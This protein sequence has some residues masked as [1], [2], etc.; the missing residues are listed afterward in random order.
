M[1]RFAWEKTLPC[2]CA[3]LVLAASA[4]HSAEARALP[5][6]ASATQTTT[7]TQ[8]A[9]TQPAATQ[10]AATQPPATPA[11]PPTQTPAAPPAQP[12]PA[13]TPAPAAAT[14]TPAGFKLCQQNNYERVGENHWHYSGSVECELE[15]ENIRFSADEIDY[16]SDTNRFLA[17]GHVVFISSGS[18]IS[19]ERA[20]FNSKT[21]TGTFFNAFG[22]ASV[23]EKIDKSFFGTQEPDAYFYGET[24]EKLGVDKYRITKGG[25]TTC[26]Q[27]TPRWEVAATS[28]TL[29]LDKRAI[30][31]NALLKV[32]DVPL[33]YLPAMYYPINKEDR[34]TG[35]LLPVY[36]TSTY[37]GSSI[38][39]AFFWAINRSQDVTLLHDWF[40]RTG[41][42]YGG[43]YRYVASA[44]S[45]GQ[46]RIYRLSE[47]SATF[48]VPNVGDITQPERRSFEV[49]ANVIQA[50]PKGFRA[51]G[52]IDYF[53]DV[54]VQQQ[55]QMDL[56]NASLRSRSYQGNVSGALGR[57]NN[58]SATYGI[59]EVFYGES[60]SQTIGG[61]PRV[62]FNRALTKLGPLPLYF[63]ASGEY[64]Q[65][66]RID[67]YGEEPRQTEIDRSLMRMDASPSLQFPVTKWPWMS[68]RSS[69][70]WRNTYWSES[71]DTRGRQIEDPV[72]R[73]YFEMRSSFTGPIISK[74]WNT[75]ENGYAERFKH[76][77]EPELI[78][79]RTTKFDEYDQ[80]VKIEGGDYTYGGTTRLTYGVTNR[81]LARRR[82]G[83]DGAPAPRAREFVNV[84]LQQSYYSNP[85]ASTVD[86]AYGGW[87]NRE[88]SNFSP[89]ALIVRGTPTN[90]VGA[91]LRLEYNAQLDEFETVQVNGNFN[92][93]SKVQ[94]NVGWSQRKYVYI[95]NPALRPPNNFLSSQTI[96]NL[97]NGKIG[98]N[99]SFDVNLSDMLLVQ[100]RIG[101][102][103]NA[104]CC[105]IG[106]EYQAFNYPNVSRFII[107]QDRRFNISFTLAG[108]GTFSNILGAFG[109]GQGATGTFGGKSY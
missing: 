47:K 6:Q 43:E 64:V 44:G 30:L 80:I 53:S 15:V 82:A 12:A 100:Q 73:Q 86:G 62:Q 5:V 50:L 77:L 74:V 24:I 90:A 28:V 60:D 69:I 97:G 85:A 52:S 106:I 109:I 91:S 102:F 19:A 41:M 104:Q 17:K 107:S 46:M 2:V 27:P 33:L 34:S 84:Q 37:R 101:F 39:N 8:P 93:A 22:S 35:F 40:T 83:A 23:S 103:Y 81:F 75:P 96:V 71:L 36:G 95:V 3:A 92:F 63:N 59:N 7:P 38:S 72:S 105:G 42:G 108:V 57:G 98:G 89:I 79:Q 54:T 25:F 14:S 32:K 26:V 29:V 87:L 58:L 1:L 88:P 76:V 20:D 66:A 11:P 68:L 9:A 16:F 49:R 65:L 48:N 56:Y 45:N 10:P 61:R 18:R 4:A 67:R 94:T 78:V 55:Y 31:K 70:T 51:R 21:R 13:P 99:Y